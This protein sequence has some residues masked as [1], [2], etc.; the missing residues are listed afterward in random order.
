MSP[1]DVCTSI[2]QTLV[3]PLRNYIM[4]ILKKYALTILVGAV[5]FSAGKFATPAKVEIREVEKV[6]YK[7]RSETKT[8]TAHTVD[9]REV[10]QPDGTRIIETTSS[11]QR[12]SDKKTAVDSSSD[13][14]RVSITE[15]RKEW[16]VSLGYE[17]LIPG[18]QSQNY[19]IHLQRRILS[20]IYLG[21]SLSTNQTIGISIGIGF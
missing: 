9:R 6:V 7:E 13:Q 12:T 5:C 15:N 11:T 21:A 10:I 14:S 20:E 2:R 19:N 1:S 3:S 4:K 8:D 16:M 17:P 18:H